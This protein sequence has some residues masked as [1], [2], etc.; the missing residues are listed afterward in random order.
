MHDDRPKCDG[1]NHNVI[2]DVVTFVELPDEHF[3]TYLAGDI[4]TVKSAADSIKSKAS[5][6]ASLYFEYC[7]ASCKEAID[8]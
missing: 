6:Q 7:C 8:G 2:L 4:G 5:P 3:R 1:T